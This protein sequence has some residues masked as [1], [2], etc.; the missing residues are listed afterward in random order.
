MTSSEVQWWNTNVRDSFVQEAVRGHR[1]EFAAKKTSSTETQGREKETY[2]RG[3]GFFAWEG[4]H[5][6]CQRPQQRILL[7]SVPGKK[8][9]QWS[10]TV[11]QS[12]RAKLLHKDVQDFHHQRRLSESI[13]R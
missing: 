1:L 8:D 12:Q 2:P 7:K 3:S 9:R 11:D 10:R 6:A 5:R 13:R 4:S